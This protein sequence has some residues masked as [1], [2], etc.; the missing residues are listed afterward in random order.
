[1]LSRITFRMFVVVMLGM[2][3]VDGAAPGT[4]RAQTVSVAIKNFSFQPS[5]L[6]V[7]IGSTVTWTNQDSV[8]HTSTSD[9]GAWDSGG[10]A[11]GQSFQHTFTAA[12]TFT[13]HCM[14]HPFMHGTI[15]VGAAVPSSMPAHPIVQAT[16]TVVPVGGTTLV[17]GSGFTS[18]NWAFVFWQRPDRTAHG[19]WVFTSSTGTFALRL[20]FSPRHGTGSEFITAFDFATRTWAP[21]AVVAV[22]AAVPQVATL[23]AAPNPVVNGGISSIVGRG[24]AP[25]TLVIVQWRRPDATAGAITIF[26]DNS[27]SFAFTLLADPRH[28]CGPRTFVAFD[29]SIGLQTAPYTLFVSC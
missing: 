22:T 24:F 6:T 27:G 28:G 26:A 4:A 20:G 23:S 18:T 10:I 17:Q 19:V 9:T 15:V 5:S 25:N 12:G 13:Y 1:M 3:V 29:P 2:L 7:P 11:P 8:E 14:I 21:F 16:P